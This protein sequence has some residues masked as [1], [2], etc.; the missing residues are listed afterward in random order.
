MKAQLVLLVNGTTWLGEADLPFAP[1]VGLG[2]RVDVYEILNVKSV[3]VGDLGYD[4][5]CVVE[6]EGA[7]RG[8]LDT[9]KCEEL[10]FRQGAYP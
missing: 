1:F 7:A 3:V 6:L 8:N 2:I 10:G 4:V 5:T 9:R